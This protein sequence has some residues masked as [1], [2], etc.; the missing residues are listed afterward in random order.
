MRGRQLQRAN[1]L[2]AHGAGIERP[3]QGAGAKLPVDIGIGEERHDAIRY[4]QTNFLADKTLVA[5]VFW[6][7]RNRGVSKH[8]FGTRRGDDQRLRWII[9]Q[10]IANIPQIAV[11]LFVHHFDVGESG[12][13]TRAPVNQPLRPIEEPI[14]PEPH[15]SFPHRQG[16][17]FVHRKALV[18]PI[19]RHAECFQL[20]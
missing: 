10:R 5:F 17:P 16:K 15:E 9:R 4:R 7:H 18:F 12:F 14:F 13:A 11:G 2:L 1:L 3:P 6:M 20:M 19:A 8:R